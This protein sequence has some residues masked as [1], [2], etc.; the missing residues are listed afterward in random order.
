MRIHEKEKK[1]NIEKIKLTQSTKPIL[2]P[3]CRTLNLIFEYI[4]NAFVAIEEFQTFYTRLW[5]PLIKVN[6][7]DNLTDKTSLIET[8]PTIQNH[9]N[10]S[11]FWSHSWVE[12]RYHITSLI[13]WDEFKIFRKY[14]LI[15][16]VYIIY[17]TLHTYSKTVF[18]YRWLIHVEVLGFSFSM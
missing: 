13:D 16:F 6:S 2:K 8:N 7:I 17:W 14:H 15:P 10:R 1:L 12:L 11:M 4:R 9:S 3:F 5:F 18:L